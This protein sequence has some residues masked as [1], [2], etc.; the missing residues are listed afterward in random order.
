MH[1]VDGK[2]NVERHN[3]VTRFEEGLWVS[4]SGPRVGMVGVEV[5][6]VLTINRFA[7]MCYT[8]LEVS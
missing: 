1:D 2:A 6:C 3:T 5:L 4:Y 7:V 8:L